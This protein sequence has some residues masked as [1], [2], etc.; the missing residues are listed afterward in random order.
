MAER[1]YRLLL[2]ATHA[3]QYASPV[4]RE[5]ARSPRLEIEVAYCSLL[6]AECG[7]DKD[8]GVE[9]KWDVPLL[10]GYSWTQEPNRARHPSLDHFF[11]LVNTSLWR[12]IPKGRYDAVVIYT[13]YRYASFWIALAAAKISGTKIMYGTDASSIA[14]R[15]GSRLKNWFKPRIVSFIFH[16][17]DAVAVPARLVATFALRQI[18][19]SAG[20]RNWPNKLSCEG[21]AS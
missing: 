15:E 9:V 21:I 4:F 3:V 16:R 5:M 19:D 10:D 18:L 11:G 6:G 20:E 7:V 2:I 13:G 14:P 17:A 8:F 1:R 12:K